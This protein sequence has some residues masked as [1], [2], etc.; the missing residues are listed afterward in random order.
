MTGGPVRA[1]VVDDS[2]TARTLLV[3]IL[4]DD[5]GIEVVGEAA[6]GREA[7]EQTQRL[8]PSVVLMDI[9]MPVL[10]GFEA[11]KR[12]MAEVPTPI[13]IVTGRREPGDV[14]TSLQATRLGALAVLPKPPGPG[15]PDFRRQA[16]RLV[17]LV[18][19]LADVKVVRRRIR[20]HSPDVSPP[21]RAD[22]HALQIV[23][24]AAST[25]GPPALYRFLG[26]LPGAFAA[27]V[28][29][30]QHIAEGF[31]DGLIR[32]LNTASPL[33]VK[34]AEHGEALSSG[35]VYVAPDDV[36]LQVDRSGRS[37][38]G[39]GAPLRGFRPS[40]SVLLSS[41]AD[42]Y[43]RSAA[44]VVLTGMGS[45]GLEGA[46]DL[47]DRGG[48]VLA[49]DERTSTVFGMP[50]AVADAGLADV[51]GSVEELALSVEKAMADEDEP[52][53]TG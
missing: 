25:G 7:V 37:V 51:V 15:S 43:G 2:T 23:G 41:L 3:E 29:V 48:L 18:K 19:A 26:A 40:G 50:R 20:Q 1:L 36:H 6:T 45:D 14:A 49:Q 16:A 42:V 53:P 31:V 21:V 46:R 38:L 8:Q 11:T 4:R 30:V 5:P 33:T 24:V 17:S 27:P 28:L 47:R 22:R 32:W 52:W 10:D 9:E 13:V 12:I 39:D 34:V 44:G 35:V